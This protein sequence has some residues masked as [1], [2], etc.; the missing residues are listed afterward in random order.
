MTDSLITFLP[1]IIMPVDQAKT[2]ALIHPVPLAAL[3]L[4][5]AVK[6]RGMEDGL[7]A[8]DTDL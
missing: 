3:F 6:A 7:L 5:V 4:R 1:A 8:N 2:L